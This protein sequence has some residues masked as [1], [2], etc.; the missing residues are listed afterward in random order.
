MELHSKDIEDKVGGYNL[1]IKNE[2]NREAVHHVLAQAKKIK[3]KLIDLQDKARRN[4]LRFDGF[5]DNGKE[6][7]NE[8][9]EK[10]KYFRRNKLGIENN[11][12]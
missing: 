3:E 7:L 8:S 11:I 10:V 1:K 4:N 9:E 2:A 12:K 6:S 5:P